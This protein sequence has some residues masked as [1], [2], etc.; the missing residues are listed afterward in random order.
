MRQHFLA[1]AAISAFCTAPAFAE[2]A[3]T[4]PPTEPYY[5]PQTT[6]CD[7]LKLKIYFEPG[8]AELTPFARDA[9]REAGEQLAGCSVSRLSTVAV[10]GDMMSEVPSVDLAENRRTTVMN[11]LSA[12]GIRS[13]RVAIETDLENSVMSRNV[14]IQM[15]TVSAPVG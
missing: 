8:T 12:H 11:E 9:I 5:A 6:T 2:E 4:P 10:A 13:S 7:M 14:D 15:Q 1:A 3:R